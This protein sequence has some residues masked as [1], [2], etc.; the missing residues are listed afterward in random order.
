[1]M[2]MLMACGCRELEREREQMRESSYYGLRCGAKVVE[3]RR[4]TVSYVQTGSVY[5][6]TEEEKA[7]T[8]ALLRFNPTGLRYTG[9]AA[10]V[11][12][13]ELHDLRIAH[14]RQDAASDNRS[15]Y[16]AAISKCRID[17]AA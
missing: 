5:W 12:A 1:M 15:N 14:F 7:I 2:V 10:K 11:L 6:L 8:G 17:N 16:D 9:D 3:K 13:R 4:G